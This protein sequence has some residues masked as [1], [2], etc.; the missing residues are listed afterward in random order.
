M[1]QELY[2]VEQIADLLGLHVRTVRHYVRDGKL[3]AIRIGKQYRIARQDL[4]AFTG[5]SASALERPPV[6]RQ[7]HIALTTVV[8]NE[9]PSPDT[10]QRLPTYPTPGLQGRP[11]TDAPARVETVYDEERARLKI[12]ISASIETTNTLLGAIA[13]LSGS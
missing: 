10:A 12:I 3:K 11:Q 6:R 8:L 2:S 5:Q 1:T 4:E 13:A 9:S 7:R